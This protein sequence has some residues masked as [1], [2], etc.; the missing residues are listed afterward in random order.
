MT[1]RI[2]VINGN[3]MQAMTDGIQR[4]GSDTASPGVEVVTVIPEVGPPKPRGL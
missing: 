1:M 4:E 2:M 3:T